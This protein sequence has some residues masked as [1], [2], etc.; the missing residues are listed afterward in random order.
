MRQRRGQGE[1]ICVE[2][3]VRRRKRRRGRRRGRWW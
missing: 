3:A 2:K 1:D